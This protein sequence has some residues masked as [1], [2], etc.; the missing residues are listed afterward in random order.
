MPKCSIP[1]CQKRFVRG[2]RLNFPVRLHSFVSI[3]TRR[4]SI[5][6]VA[7]GVLARSTAGDRQ[8]E[9]TREQAESTEARARR[10]YAEW[11]QQRI[12]ASLEP[13]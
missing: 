3:C 1:A 8:A 7:C 12:G 9:P 13:L 11:L 6:F 10:E 4:S 2:C 5:G